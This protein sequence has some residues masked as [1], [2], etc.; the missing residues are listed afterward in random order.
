M[1]FCFTSSFLTLLLP[2]FSHIVTS[3][4]VSLVSA[5]VLFNEISIITAYNYITEFNNYNFI[6]FN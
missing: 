2:P 1:N 5:V 6:L 3:W 4:V